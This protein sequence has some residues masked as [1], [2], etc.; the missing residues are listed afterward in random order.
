VPTVNHQPSTI[1][2][3][4][5][6]NE[7]NVGG[8][9]N[10]L[11]AFRDARVKR[12]VLASSSSVYGDSETLPKREDMTPQPLSPY[13][14]SKLAA[15]KYCQVFARIYGLE[16]VCL[17]YFNVFGPRQN[18]ASQYAAVI[19]KFIVAMQ[20][21]Q[22]PVIYGDG[23]QSR[24]FTYV[25]NNVMAN[26]LACESS[27]GSGEVFNIACGER[28]SLLELVAELNRLLGTSLEPRLE[29]ARPGD[30]RH[31]LAD[32]TKAQ[33]ELGFMVQTDFRTGLAKTVASLRS[34]LEDPLQHFSVR[35]RKV[36]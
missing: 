26:L 25:D 10:L 16:T 5:T 24:D 34:G 2:D 15:E 4:I 8:T 3:P 9:L 28:Y 13:A 36:L 20:Q 22:P 29:P 35:D 18:P 19:P 31:S 17:R 23:L 11:D 27:N 32:I 12:F 30:V 21:G 33:R 6:T 1:R 14:V 7:V